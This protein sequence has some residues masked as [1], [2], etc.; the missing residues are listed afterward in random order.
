[1]IVE[2]VRRIQFELIKRI[3]GEEQHKN[4]FV[5]ARLGGFTVFQSS[6]CPTKSACACLWP[7]IHQCSAFVSNLDLRPM[8]SKKL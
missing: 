1:M 8:H 4:F 6:S 5:E 3:E 2:P 7:A